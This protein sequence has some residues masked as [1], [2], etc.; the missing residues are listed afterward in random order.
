MNK[1][2]ALIEDD[3][4]LRENYS[5]AFAKQG[6]KV[7]AFSNRSSAER[8]FEKQL[9]DLAIIDIGLEDELEGGFHLCQSLRSQSQQL[10]IIFL[11][12][13]DNDFDTTSGLR[14]GADDYLTKDISLPHLMARIAA[15][16]RRN[17]RF[18][19]HKATLMS[20]LSVWTQSV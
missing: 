5:T 15:L 18:P 6:Y 19:L 11:T 13:R 8:H 4:A 3:V 2:I 7:L 16:F 1:L 14:M 17:E 20:S 9:P 12:A 10:P